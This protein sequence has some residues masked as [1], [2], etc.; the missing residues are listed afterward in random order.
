MQVRYGD[1]KVSRWGVY[2]EVKIWF[3]DGCSNQCYNCYEGFYQYCVVVDE[4][5]VGFISQQFWC[6]IGRDQCV[7]VRYCIIGDGDEQEWEQS[8]FLQWVSIVNV[9]GYGRYFQ[10]WV[11]Y[12]DIQCQVDDNVDFQEGC[13]IVVW[14]E[15]QLYWQQCGNKCI[16]NQC[17]G[18]GGVFKG[19]C[20]ILVWIVSNYVIEVDRGNQ[21]YDI[22]D[23]DFIY[24]FW[25]NKVYVDIHKQRNRYG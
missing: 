21:Q 20:W 18:N 23:R 8:V 22:N 24:M 6:C 5:C 9:L 19:Q 17:E 15:D 7:E 2:C 16:V 12:Y 3:D 10:F 25:M 14:C 4:M 11:Q 13:Q 1:V